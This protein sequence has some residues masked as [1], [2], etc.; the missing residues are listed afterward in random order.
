VLEFPNGHEH[1]YMLIQDL[2]PQWKM[3]FNARKPLEAVYDTTGKYLEVD[4]W[5]PDLKVG[6]EYQVR[7]L[8]LK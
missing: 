8:Q 4:V 6:F 2:F 3:Q 1:F 7:L 5:I